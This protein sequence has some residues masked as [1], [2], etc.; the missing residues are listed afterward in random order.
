MF[1]AKSPGTWFI[2]VSL[3]LRGNLHIAINC[4]LW[5][6][7]GFASFALGSQGGLKQAWLVYLV[8]KCVHLAVISNTCLRHRIKSLKKCFHMLVP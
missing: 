2:C 8:G 3:M 5:G 7:Q 1:G 4:T 6:V